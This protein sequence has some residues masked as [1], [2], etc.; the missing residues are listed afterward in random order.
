M[1]FDDRFV[2]EE[3]HAWGG[4]G[5]NVH[6]VLLFLEDHDEITAFF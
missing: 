4:F 1:R 3:R 2:V 5:V 6:D